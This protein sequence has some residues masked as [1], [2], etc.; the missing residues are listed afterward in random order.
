MSDY[1][2]EQIDLSIQEASKHAEQANGLYDMLL[3]LQKN[4]EFKKV[5]NEF[6]LNEE[7]VRLTH[8]L[9][10][11][12]WS[13]ED[14]QREIVEDLKAIAGLK[15]FFLKLRQAA[16]QSTHTLTGLEALREEVLA[17]EAEA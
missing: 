11:P 12:A 1:S 13:T 16:A 5:I 8:L 3:K 2:L 14:S 17:E 7:A 10:D 6:Y 15:K 4:R 9:A